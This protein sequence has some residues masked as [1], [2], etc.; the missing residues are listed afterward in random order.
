MISKKGWGDGEARKG[1]GVT[2]ASASLQRKWSIETT[3][4]PGAGKHL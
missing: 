3:A 1:E 2:G 4:W